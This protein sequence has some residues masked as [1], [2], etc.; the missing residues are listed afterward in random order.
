[1][2]KL[3]AL[4]AAACLTGSIT[5]ANSAIVFSKPIQQSQ[6]AA[7]QKPSADDER[8]AYA[9]YNACHS[10][11]DNKKKI[12]M[13][14]EALKL[15][16]NSQYAPYF[17]QELDA[18]RGAI[19]TQ[20]LTANDLAAAFPAADEMLKDNPEN[21]GILVTLAEAGARAAKSPK[22]DYSFADKST[23]YAKKSIELINAG[24]QPP[25]VPDWDK[26][27]PQV[28]GSMHQDI[29]LFLLKAK[30]EDEAL[31][32]LTEASK[33][34][35]SDPVT[36]FLISKI[37]YA[38]YDAL[39]NDYRALSDED[40]AGD[41]GKALLEKINAAVDVVLED[42]GKMIAV[43]DGKVENGKPIYEGLV[44]Q[45]KPVMTDLYKFRHDNSDATMQA[46][47]DGFKTACAPK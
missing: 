44:K 35:C 28:L 24:K 32:E 26:R 38:K 37:H 34:D 40:K 29:G 6:P 2:K 30:K 21:L 23:E 14:Q 25:N 5:L 11:T 7:G 15:Y 46:Y 18:A 13:A 9:A 20:A 1:M 27:K 12:D 45:V 43:A 36:Y 17:K 41:K 4:L 39:G 8:K 47:I 33:N 22:A 16:P 42:Y 31:T 10:E 3:S 19:L